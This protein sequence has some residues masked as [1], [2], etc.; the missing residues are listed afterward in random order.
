MSTA[1][2]PTGFFGKL[3]ARAM[4]RGHKDFYINTARVLNLSQDDKYLEIGFGSGVFIEEYASIVAKVA[5]LDISEDMVNLAESINAELVTSGKAEFRQ[6]DVKSIPW[7]DNEFT[8]VCGIETF[9]FWPEPEASLKEIF[10]VLAPGGRVVIEMGFNKDDGV[11]HAKNV[12]RHGMRI[13][14]SEEMKKLLDEAGFKN[15]SVEYYQAFKVP[16]KG[17]VVPK[18]MI[19]KAYK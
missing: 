18:G 6:G 11:D 7:D 10:R 2:K 1:G 8:A 9:Y 3:M 14:S 17:Y 5:G 12:K 4:A 19:V 13:Y 15:I 16:I